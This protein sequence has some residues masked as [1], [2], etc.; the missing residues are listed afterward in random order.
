MAGPV[1][2]APMILL[3]ASRPGSV[4]AERGKVPPGR[5]IP[6]PS[7]TAGSPIQTPEFRRLLQAPS[8][9]LELLESYNHSHRP[10]IGAGIGIGI[11]GIFFGQPPSSTQIHSIPIATPAPTCL[12]RFFLW[13]LCESRSGAT[14][15]PPTPPPCPP[16]CN[17]STIKIFSSLKVL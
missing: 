2:P 5:E 12:D 13:D 17:S 9:L 3:D 15:H 14:P 11:G 10:F 7:E 4:V 16:T 1:P 6:F 8:V